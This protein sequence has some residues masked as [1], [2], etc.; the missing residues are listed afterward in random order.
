MVK[1]ITMS[2]TYKWIG[3]LLM[4]GFTVFI[5]MIIPERGGTTE[6]PDGGL[7]DQEK[8]ITDTFIHEGKVS[9]DY[10]D[11][12]I[13]NE[14][15][16]VGNDPDR[17]RNAI[18]NAASKAYALIMTVAGGKVSMV[19]AKDGEVSDYCKY[20][21]TLTESVATFKEQSDVASL[22]NSSL[23]ETQNII[24]QK[25]SLYQASRVYDIKSDVG[26][27]QAYGWGATASCYTGMVGYSA[28]TGGGAGAWGTTKSVGLKLS[29]AALLSWFFYDQS[30]RQ[31]EYAEEVKVIAEKLPSV[32]NCNPITEVDCYCAQEETKNDTKYCKF[33]TYNRVSVTNSIITAC[34]DDMLKNDP[35]CNC[36]KTNTC[37]SQKFMNQVKTLDFGSGITGD[38]AK[39][40]TSLSNGGIKTGQ[41]LAEGTPLTYAANSKTL[42]KKYDNKIKPPS[43]LMANQLKDATNLELAGISP[44][45]SKYL[46][47]IPHN[48]QSLR[49]KKRLAGMFSNSKLSKNMASGKSSSYGEVVYFN[50]G[51]SNKNKSKRSFKIPKLKKKS[52]APSGEVINFNIKAHRKAQITRVKDAHLFHIISRRY[53]TR[54]VELMLP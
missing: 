22:K 48:S 15:L 35:E 7:T 27:I 13:G 17:S 52:R 8:I 16:C 38:V 11:A 4:V 40:V 30:E 25:E 44:N 33:T 29:A 36:L 53:S 20:I 19:G 39:A 10:L 32:G 41:V 18:L 26:K 24:E 51:S 49:A 3:L 34:V 6:L 5:F 23:I 42:L 14:D 9:R 31:K 37:Y 28:I 43:Y 50:Q 54:S 46:S 21:A 1:Y 2:I 47:T 45:L 12:C